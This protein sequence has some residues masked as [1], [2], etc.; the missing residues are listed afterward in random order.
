[1]D[2][3]LLSTKGSV[4]TSRAMASAEGPLVAQNWAGVG[5]ADALRHAV[6]VQRWRISPDAS[7]PHPR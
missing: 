5:P 4:L 6:P 7:A 1:M 3:G 2:R